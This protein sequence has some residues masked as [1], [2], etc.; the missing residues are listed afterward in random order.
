MP[1]TAPALP[2]TV[3]FGRQGPTVTL[4]LDG[5]EF[6]FHVDA[7]PGRDNSD[8]LRALAMAEHLGYEA[9][10]PEECEPETLAD[11]TERIFLVPSDLETA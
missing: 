1:P 7:P 9:I 3:D 10:P 2:L 8:L 6:D 4:Y 11:G 5:E